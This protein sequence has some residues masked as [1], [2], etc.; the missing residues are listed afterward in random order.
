MY[1][2]TYVHTAT[3]YH[4]HNFTGGVD[5]IAG[6]YP[7]NFPTGHTNA[8]LNVTII[9]DNISEGNENFNLTIESSS[10]PSKVNINDL[11]EA[12]VTIVDNEG[13]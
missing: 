12:I 6:P 2:A 4:I 9:D 7:V 13:K 3:S 5:Y 1:I 10:L 11:A 8:T